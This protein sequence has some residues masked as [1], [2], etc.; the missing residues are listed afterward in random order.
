MQQQI[1]DTIQGNYWQGGAGYGS[2]VSNLLYENGA[3]GG[4]THSKVPG[5]VPSVVIGYGRKNPNVA[6][7]RTGNKK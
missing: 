7:K 1:A 6:K 5:Q 2:A 4:S 3:K